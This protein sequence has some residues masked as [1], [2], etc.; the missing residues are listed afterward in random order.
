M[1]KREVRIRWFLNT[2]TG[3][4]AIWRKKVAT[5]E[6][7]KLYPKS[8]N[9]STLRIILRN[10]HLDHIIQNMVKYFEIISRLRYFEVNIYVSTATQLDFFSL[11]INTPHNSLIYFYVLSESLFATYYSSSA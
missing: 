4:R 6:Q 8:T 9:R 3:W 1:T 7:G 11:T 2:Q 10:N 5:R